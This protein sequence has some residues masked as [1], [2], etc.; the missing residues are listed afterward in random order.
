MNEQRNRK[1]QRPRAGGGPAPVVP[2]TTGRPWRPLDL[3]VTG[4]LGLVFVYQWMFNFLP[5]GLRTN[6][7]AAIAAGLLLLSL[8]SM[9]LAPKFWRLLAT[10]A[11]IGIVG[12]WVVG[13][14]MGFG[15]FQPVH[16]VRFLVPLLFGMWLLDSG[17]GLR[18]EVALAFCATTIG[19]AML[20]AVLNPSSIVGRIHRFAPFTGGEDGAHASAYM[21]ALCVLI[22]YQLVLNG[23][24]TRRLGWSIIG[25]GAV[26]LLGLRVATPIFMLLNFALVH[27]LLTR[28]MGTAAKVGIWLSVAASVGGLVVWHEAQ[29]AE[30]AGGELQNVGDVGSGRLGAWLYRLYLLGQRDVFELLFGKGPGSDF[31]V[32][33]QWWWEA[34]DSHHDLLRITMESG[35]VGVSLVVIF[36]WLVLRA[37]GKDGWPLFWFAMA[38]SMIS[39]GLMH[40][41]YLA[42]LFWIA[43]TLAMQ[44]VAMLRARQGRRPVPR[45]SRPPA[46]RAPDGAPMPASEQGSSSPRPVPPRRPATV[47]RL[48]R[49]Y[50]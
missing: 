31:I 27:V 3:V 7:A 20:W 14:A 1:W 15:S 33:P 12:C 21:V 4:A 32:T 16:A 25:L 41:P 9:L 2:P 8:A 13:E 24:V 10:S 5:D 34:K 39:N 30:L 44:R 28:Q 43:V 40:R 38:G 46:P 29:Q 49:D 26:Y 18:S 17:R 47:H 48:R 50:R 11:L 36:F 42:V 35:F 23:Q 22:M 6:L 19:Y 45:R 37:L